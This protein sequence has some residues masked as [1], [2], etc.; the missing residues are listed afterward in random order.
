MFLC[1]MHGVIRPGK[2]KADV[3]VTSPESLTCA[4]R[5]AHEVDCAS[6]HPVAVTHLIHAHSHVALI[7]WAA[8]LRGSNVASSQ[9]A[10]MVAVTAATIA[11]FRVGRATR[12]TVLPTAC[13]L[14]QGNVL[15]LRADVME[16]R[17]ERRST[18]VLTRFPGRQLTC[19]H[20][21]L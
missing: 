13:K 12:A 19:A 9:A 15:D 11:I 1:G 4:H 8:R 20:R 21:Q 10:R 6:M 2:M 18:Q 5:I 16:D 17:G 7:A 3:N 14:R